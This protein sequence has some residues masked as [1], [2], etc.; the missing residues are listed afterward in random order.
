[1]IDGWRDMAAQ[2]RCQKTSRPLQVVRQDR[3]TN[4]SWLGSSGVMIKDNS[5]KYCV[6]GEIPHCS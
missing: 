6:V 3:E 5:S 4:D 1:M 2:A